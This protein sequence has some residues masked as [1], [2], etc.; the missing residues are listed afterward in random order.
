MC[1]IPKGRITFY[2]YDEANLPYHNLFCGNPNLE[3]SEFYRQQ[4]AELNQ[5]D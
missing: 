4:E 2:G 1:V 5:I 3:N